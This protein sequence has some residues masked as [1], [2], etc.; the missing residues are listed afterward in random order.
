MQATREHDGLNGVYS[1]PLST[2]AE[3]AVSPKPHQGVGDALRK[4]Y[5]AAAAEIPP[6]WR[7]LL[8]RID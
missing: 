6:E 3:L 1:L 7:V 8:D 2:S 4:T 5:P